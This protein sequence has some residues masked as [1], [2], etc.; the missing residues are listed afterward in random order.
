MDN[1]KKGILN[2]KFSYKA[3]PDG[4]VDKTKVICIYSDSD[5]EEEEEDSIE[6]CVER[7][8]AEPTVVVDK[9]IDKNVPLRYILNR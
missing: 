6:R 9:M 2:G 4:S 7:Y 5:D 3:L 8:R 1:E